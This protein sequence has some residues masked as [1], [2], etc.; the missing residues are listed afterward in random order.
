MY[1]QVRLHSLRY[2]TT[3][4][5]QWIIQENCQCSLPYDFSVNE[6]YF[7]CTG[8][9]YAIFRA[10]LSPS[11]LWNETD[12]VSVKDNLSNLLS[13]HDRKTYITIDDGRYFIEPGPCGLTVPQLNPQ[14]CLD[15]APTQ[16]AAV[17]TL[18]QDDTAAA[19]AVVAI[20]SVSMVLVVFWG[21]IVFFLSL[22]CRKCKCKL[23]AQHMHDYTV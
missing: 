7:I 13:R 9:D 11:D 17:S 19:L 3:R 2:G 23:H 10:K 14:H 1:M 4:E 8:S 22:D 16:Q 21:C 18:S 20:M 5:V 12:Q 6:G 15:I